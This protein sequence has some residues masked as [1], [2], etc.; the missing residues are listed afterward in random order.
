M[1]GPSGSIRP[2]E[3]QSW[4]KRLSDDLAPATIG[5]VHR[6]VA[7]VFNAAVRDRKI[8]SSPCRGSR[9]PKVAREHWDHRRRDRD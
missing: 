2:S 1:I 5:V 6:I 4:I 3:V 8:P 9:L 7:S